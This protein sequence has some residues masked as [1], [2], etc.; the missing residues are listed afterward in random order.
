MNTDIDRARHVAAQQHKE[1]GEET[2][3]AFSRRRGYREETQ[4]QLEREDSTEE[5]NEVH[6]RFVLLLEL[7]AIITNLNL[8]EHRPAEVDIAS[9]SKV[10]NVTRIRAFLRCLLAEFLGTGILVYF[11]GENLD[12]TTKRH[13]FPLQFFLTYE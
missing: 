6:P 3:E 4:D 1:D 2:T 7:S 9:G 8:N 5:P 11:H 13:L 12:S 10:K